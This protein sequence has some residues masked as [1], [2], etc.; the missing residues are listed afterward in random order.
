MMVWLMPVG[1]VARPLIEKV[2]A[3]SVVAV[4]TVT[5]PLLPLIAHDFGCSVGAAGIVVSAFVVPDLAAAR[6]A[7]TQCGGGL[8]GA[9]RQWVF[10][11]WTVCDGHDPE[12]NVVQ[13]RAAT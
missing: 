12:G 8:N 7:A 1:A 5:A 4:M 10:Q 6:L 3:M 11:G 2:P 9:E 13:F